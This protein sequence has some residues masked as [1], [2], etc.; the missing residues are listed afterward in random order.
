MDQ[1]FTCFCSTPSCRGFISGAKEMSPSQLEGMWL[2]AHIR[3]L[4]E[5]HSSPSSSPSSTSSGNGTPTSTPTSTDATELALSENL[6]LARKM[7]TA[8]QKAL[9]TYK[10]LHGKE[11]AGAM[12]G[13]DGK[14]RENG[15]GSRELS[16]EMG[17]DTTETKARRGV[18]S[19]EMSGEMGGD[20]VA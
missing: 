2:N 19:R 16:G 5:S 9:D 12:N 4:L 13:K 3:S 14:V 18:T 6:L 15:V 7:V 17:G 1:P 8:A 20:T 10:S 11:D